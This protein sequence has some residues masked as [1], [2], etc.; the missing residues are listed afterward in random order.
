MSDSAQ[1]YKTRALEK[2]RDDFEHARSYLNDKREDLQTRYVDPSLSFVA[3]SAQRNP[4]P[5]LFLALF[6]AFSFV[7]VLTFL[8]FA[9]G[10]VVIVGG[11]ALLA[12]GAV[13][14]W[15][16]G[17][18]ALLLVG[19]VIVTAFLAAGATASFVS[20]YAAYRFFALLGSA[21]T[22][23]DALQQFQDEAVNL[24]KGSAEQDAPGAGKKVRINGIA[25]Q[26]G[27]GD[28]AVKLDGQT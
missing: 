24:V 15:L 14:A 22:L 19:A 6:A 28:V 21:Q 25:K 1:D 18:G 7:P 5:T 23:P 27:E 2:A 16:V 20:A 8:L 13:T 12:A 3:A 26:E 4:L 10:S 11:G 9:V 17:T